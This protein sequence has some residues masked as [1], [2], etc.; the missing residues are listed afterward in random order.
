MEGLRRSRDDPDVRAGADREVQRRNT[1]DDDRS[2]AVPMVV[3][4]E[5]ELFVAK[6]VRLSIH[7]RGYPQRN[8]WWPLAYRMRTTGVL[9]RWYKAVDEAVENRLKQPHGPM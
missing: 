9:S 3:Y 2:I 6:F 5:A 1:C 7:H 4:E 8:E